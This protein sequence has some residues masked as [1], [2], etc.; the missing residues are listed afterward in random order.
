MLAVH[1]MKN[2]DGK[3]WNPKF[4]VLKSVL[5][6]SSS[7]CLSIFYF[8]FLRFLLLTWLLHLVVQGVSDLFLNC[9][10]EGE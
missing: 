3:T 4:I 7:S 8:S 6:L 1:P 10:W 9:D 5:S 2:P